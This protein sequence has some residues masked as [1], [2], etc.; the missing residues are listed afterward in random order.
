MSAIFNSLKSL[1]DIEYGDLSPED[2]EEVRH[3]FHEEC[4]RRLNAI[5]A[6]AFFGET[7]IT[8]MDFLAGFY[9][10]NP[11]NLLNLVGAACIVLSSLIV[12]ARCNKLVKKDCT[13]HEG[14]V[15][16]LR[17]YKIMLAIGVCMFIFTDIVVRHKTT[18]AYLVFL[19]VFQVIPF[20][21]AA[22][23]I[24]V[25][26][27]FAVLIAV[28]Y[29]AAVPNA[30][31]GTL[32]SILSILFA[33]GFST[34]CMRSFSIK[35]TI[36]SR[37]NQRMTE[38]FSRLA[39]QTI[40]ALS[41]AVEAKDL[42][43]RGHSQ[44]VAEYSREL[45]RRM[46][47]DEVQQHEVYCIGLL[48]D[49]GKLGI[50]DAV[51][52]KRGALTDEEFAAIK[53]HPLIGHDILKTI[54]EMPSISIGARWH[55][56]RPNGRGYPDGLS[57]DEIPEIARIIAVADAYDAMTSTRS[58]RALMPQDKVRS[59]IV[60]NIGTQFFPEVANLM[61]QMIDEDT[62]YRMHG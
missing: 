44:R 41:N 47:Y 15:K 53:Q 22:A 62:E 58:Y 59:E 31:P 52:N 25:Y 50:N 36:S 49:I 57:G 20:Y 43:T 56:E 33:F 3:Q 55:H 13:D 27:V 24:G 45:A 61:L 1:F 9:S 18:G 4:V 17:F 51:I 7:I 39:T 2:R 37:L 38:R 21:D 29:L 34:E 60:K 23:N 48:H 40:L 28:L 5:T 26:S 11:L 16:L 10:K 30:K 8:V 12:N 6:L 46:G 19:F 54:T 32:F 14:R 42:Y 35:K